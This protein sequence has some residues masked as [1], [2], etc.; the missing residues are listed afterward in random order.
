MSD[1]MFRL[2]ERHQK[3]DRLIRAAQARRTGDPFEVLRLKKL[4]L[5]LKDRISRM[6]R[7]PARG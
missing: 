3:L 6:T 7:T 4:K 2:M 1:R 5:A